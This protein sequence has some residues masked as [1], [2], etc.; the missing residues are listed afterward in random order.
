MVWGGITFSSKSPLH[1]VNGNLNGEQYISQIIDPYILPFLNDNE[2]TI[3]QQDN[4]K[5]HTARI[6][7]EHLNDNNI[8]P[9][10]WPAK[11]ADLNPIEHIWDALDRSIGNRAVQPKNLADLRNALVE[12]WNNFPQYKIRK[13]IASMRR[14]C[15]AVI[16]ARGGHT[17]Y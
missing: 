12:E 1:V 11:S 5:P 10:S 3:F 16:D 17:R 9:L 2:G 14:R 7:V 15:Q 8:Q 13:L 6:T 4:A